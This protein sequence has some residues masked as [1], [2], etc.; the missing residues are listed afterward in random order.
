MEDRKLG[1]RLMRYI[2]SAL[3]G[4]VADIGTELMIPGTGLGE[5][6]LGLGVG[7]AV[8]GETNRCLKNEKVVVEVEKNI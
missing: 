6:I 2:I 5:K 4:I 7:L 8:A 1:K 3:F